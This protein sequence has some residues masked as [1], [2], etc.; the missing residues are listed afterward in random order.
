MK[1][2]Y[3]IEFGHT[4]EVVAETEDEAIEQAVALLDGEGIGDILEITSWEVE[5]DDK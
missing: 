5:E 4:V 2:I 1:K 3:Q